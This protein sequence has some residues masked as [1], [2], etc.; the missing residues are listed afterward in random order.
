MRTRS[1]SAATALAVVGG[2]GCVGTAV[3]DGAPTVAT[4]NPGLVTG[5]II[6]IPIKLR[7]NICGNTIDVILGLANPASGRACHAVDR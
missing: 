4:H 2:L 6:Q 7:P 5:N 1:V 3:A